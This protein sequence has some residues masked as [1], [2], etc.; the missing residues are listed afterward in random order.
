MPI[1]AITTQ[2]LY[3]HAAEQL[4]ELIRAGEYGPGAKLPPARDLAKQLGVSRPTVR[5][6]L[7]SLELAG[8]VEVRIGSGAF[9][10]QRGPGTMSPA[11]GT[12]GADTGAGAFELIAARKLVEPPI[13]A[14]AAQTITEP[15]LAALRETLHLMENEAKDRDHWEKLEIDRQFHLGIAQATHNTVLVEVVDKLWKEM[16][17]PIFALLS[18]RTAL[19]KKQYM[20]LSDHHAIY[21]CIERR[22]S[23]AAHAAMLSHLVNVELTLLEEADGGDASEPPR[24]G[25]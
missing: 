4:A 13:A 2:R 22:D 21:G 11:G 24:R 1:Q 15:E 12:I 8:L 16:F 9:V 14:T 6:A 17:G 20:T 19:T 18:E 5:E 7:L 3:Q 10:K 25:G 23:L